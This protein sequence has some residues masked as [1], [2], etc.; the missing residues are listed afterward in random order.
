MSDFELVI[1]S[2]NMFFVQNQFKLTPFPFAFLGTVYNIAYKPHF[3]T[4]QTGTDQLK[5]ITQLGSWKIVVRMESSYNWLRIRFY[6]V[7]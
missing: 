4:G 6:L 5:I 1:L 3:F 2:F 7:G